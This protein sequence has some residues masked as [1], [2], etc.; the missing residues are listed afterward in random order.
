[1][2]NAEQ[3]REHWL[4]NAEAWAEQTMA[5][6]RCGDLVTAKIYA[7]ESKQRSR[8]CETPPGT[9]RRRFRTDKVFEAPRHGNDCPNKKQ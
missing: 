6:R 5:A 8:K 9:N 1:M 7:P 4:R 3:E 2:Q